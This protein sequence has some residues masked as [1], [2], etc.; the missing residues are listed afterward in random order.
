MFQSRPTKVLQRATCFSSKRNHRPSNCFA[1]FSVI[2]VVKKNQFKEV[3]RR[4]YILEIPSNESNASK[5]FLASLWAVLPL[6]WDQRRS[7]ASHQSGW[8]RTWI[9][10]CSSPKRRFDMFFSQNCPHILEVYRLF[11][12]ENIFWF[13]TLWLFKPLH[14]GNCSISRRI[15]ISSFFTWNLVFGLDRGICL[16]SV[17]LSSE[18][19]SKKR[20]CFDNWRTFAACLAYDMFEVPKMVRPRSLIFR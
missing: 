17:F 2:Q 1:F 3:P 6:K 16:K 5:T 19:P 7:L 8:N 14:L 13:K 15:R 11:S 20:R 18:H 12:W 4:L 10:C 9:R